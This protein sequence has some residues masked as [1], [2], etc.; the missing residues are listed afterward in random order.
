MHYVQ[1]DRRVVSEFAARRPDMQFN[2]R[3]LR[4]AVQ[5]IEKLRYAFAETVDLLGTNQKISATRPT[6]FNEQLKTVKS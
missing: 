6:L 1:L 5:A 2:A 3:L 4:A